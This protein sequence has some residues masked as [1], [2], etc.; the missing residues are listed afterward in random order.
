M[1]VMARWKDSNNSRNAGSCILQKPVKMG[2]SF[3]S[4]KTEISVSG[5]L[6]PASRESTGLIQC[7]L[8]AANCS[9]VMEP[10]IT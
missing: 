7:A 6:K 9:S 10:D 5:F 3:G 2:T 4:S 1:K 8:I